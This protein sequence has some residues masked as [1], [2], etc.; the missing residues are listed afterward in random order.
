M[1]RRGRGQFEFTLVELGVLAASFTATAVLVFFLG[2]YVGRETAARHTPPD[3]RV[4]RVP[5]TDPPAD[6]LAAPAAGAEEAAAN[7][8]APQPAARPGPRPRPAEPPPAEAEPADDGS[9]PA[10]AEPSPPAE[11]GLDEDGAGADTGEPDESEDA[12]GAGQTGGYTVQ[13]LATRNPEEAESMVSDLEGNGYGAFVT[14]VEDA[15]GKWYRVR[16]GRYE[17]PQSARIMAE[18]CKKDLGLSQAYV[19]PY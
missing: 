9:A 2:F 14:P 19:S 15:G 13:V 3:E 12:G 8:P 4:A 16:I 17:D 1:A 5:V 7:E 10:A 6:P 11:P 18:R